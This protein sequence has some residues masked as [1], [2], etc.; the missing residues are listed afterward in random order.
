MCSKKKK[1][2]SAK[3]L[4]HFALRVCEKVESKGQTTYN[5]V[6]DE[7]VEEFT[8]G[9]NDGNYVSFAKCANNNFMCLFFSPNRCFVSRNLNNW[10]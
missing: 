1:S 8:D 7:L 4:R 2:T 5:E 10:R 3:G 6:A 9:T